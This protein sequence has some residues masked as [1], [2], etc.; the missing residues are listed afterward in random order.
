MVRNYPEPE[1]SSLQCP[2][3]SPSTHMW[4]P[5]ICRPLQSLSAE[6]TTNHA[7]HAEV[8][9]SVYATKVFLSGFPKA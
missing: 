8:T 5:Q 2:T 3:R 4:G 1:P 9:M 6:G 7:P